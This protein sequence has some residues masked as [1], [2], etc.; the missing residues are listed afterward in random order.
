[1]E[2][3]E[4]IIQGCV[5]DELTCPDCGC[6]HHQVKGV[7]KYAFFFVESISFFPVEKNTIIQCQQCWVKTDVTALPK[8]RVRVIKKSVS[9]LATHQQV[10]RFDLNANVHRLFNTGRI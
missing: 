1:M 9:C 5:I 4:Q 8:Q 3:S 7:I 10:L 6:N 2:Y